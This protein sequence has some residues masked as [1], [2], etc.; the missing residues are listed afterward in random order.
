M[1]HNLRGP[2]RDGVLANLLQ[3]LSLN[4]ANGCLMLSNAR[5]VNGE[6]FVQRGRVIHAVAGYER[7]LPAVA[8]MLTWLDGSFNFRDGITPTE[9]TID[10]PLER[11]LLDAA[12][13]ADTT[14]TTIQS[15]ISPSTVLRPGNP[16]SFGATIQIPGAAIH[17][18][19]LLD[20]YRSLDEVSHMIGMQIDEGVRLARELLNLGVVTIESGPQVSNAFIEDL[21]S[22]VVRVV[23]PVGEI[24]VED[25]ILDLDLDRDAVP[26]KSV[27]KLVNEIANQIKNAEQRRRFE[28]GIQELRARHRI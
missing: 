14:D 16:G 3:Y 4:Q 8:I 21:S 25:S 17:L 9:Q 13:Y 18:L 24:I 27:P 10:F 23:G 6:I 15:N 1:V 2:L 20:G 7:A 5:G 26:L 12:Y 28:Q 19:R 11:L 22:L